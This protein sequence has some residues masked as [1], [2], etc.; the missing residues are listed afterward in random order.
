MTGILRKSLELDHEIFIGT[1]IEYAKSLVA[2][3]RV[4]DTNLEKH[5]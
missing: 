5:Q 3:K 4:I 2:L 1:N